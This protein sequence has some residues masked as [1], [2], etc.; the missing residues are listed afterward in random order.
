METAVIVIVALAVF[1][2]VFYFATNKA[3]SNETLVE[4]S[5]LVKSSNPLDDIQ[6]R[7]PENKVY[8]EQRLYAG[9]DSKNSYIAIMS[10]EITRGLALRGL[11]VSVYAIVQGGENVCPEGVCSGARIVV[12]VGGCNCIYFND[13]QIVVE[14]DEKFL[15]DQAVRTGRLIGYAVYK[16]S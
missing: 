1:A 3:R 12:A 13:T 9:N 15:G 14:G 2:G 5:L 11:N 4:G 6:K 8:V 16:R 10:A 7:I